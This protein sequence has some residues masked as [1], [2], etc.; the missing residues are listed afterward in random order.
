M[1]LTVF[2]GALSNGAVGVP[3][4]DSLAANGGAPPY[5]WSIVSG[6][7][8]DGFS[9]TSSGTIS[10]TPSRAGTFSFS[11]RATDTTGG[12]NA[13]P[14]SI[15]I[16]PPA[17]TIS[18][19]S[20]PSAIAS[21]PY[22]PQMIAVSGGTQPY[23]FKLD[24]GSL[25]AGLS[26]T[27]GQISGTPTA[28]GTSTFTLT[29]TDANGSS[30]SVP[31]SILVK[32]NQADLILSSSSLSFSLAVG[33]SALPAPASVTVSSSVASQLLTWSVT[34]SPAAL[35]LDVSGGGSTP[36]GIDISLDPQAANLQAAASPYQGAVTITCKAPSPC[37][38][39]SQT[40][41]V[42]LTVNTPPPALSVPTSLVSFSSTSDNPQPASQSLTLQNSGGGAIRVRS[43]TA[44]DGWVSIGGAPGS[45]TGGM[46]AAFPV[47]VNPTGLSAGYYQS[48]ISV[49]TSVGTVTVPVA[50]LIARSQTMNV[51]PA[52]AQFTSA[53]S[54]SFVVSVSGNTSILWTAAAQ[55]GASWL[56]VT[57]P[58][59][60]ST[61]S[62][63]GTVS[64]SIDP[65]AA[66]ALGPGTYYGIIAVS[67]TGAI[68][69]PLNF[70]V[71]LTIPQSGA[72]TALDP[73]PAGLIFLATVVGTAP[74]QAIQVN[75]GA[76]TAYQAAATTS[77]GANWLSV[78][79]STGNSTPAS[80]GQSN[81]S[82]NTG[83]LA[84]G[85]YT[86]GVSY[87]ANGAVRTVNVTL[88]V[89][90]LPPHTTNGNNCT[91]TKLVPTQIGLANN[92]GETAGLP[93]PL[94][95]NLTD[96]CG[97]VIT[98]GQVSVSFSNGD[99]PLSLAAVDTQSG[100]YSGTWTPRN[101]SPQVTVSVLA[102]QAPLNSA[103]S[104]ITGQVTQ[105]SVPLLTPH[106]TLHVFAPTIG[107]AVA[108][109][110]IIQIYGSNLSSG[111]AAASTIPLP[112]SLSG[113][114]VMI[115]GLA[116]PLYYVSPTQINAFAPFELV[117]GA[118]YQV[119]V[120]SSQ[121]VSTPDSVQITNA[122]PG[123]AAL[124]S[125]LAIAQ[126]LD[127]TLVN[128]TSPAR[129][130]EFVIFYLAGLGETDNA[131]ATG[132]ASPSNPLARPLAAV[133]V[134][135]NG[136]NVPVAFAGLT[137]GLVGLYQINLQVPAGTPNGD[138]PLIVSQPGAT[139]NTAILAVHQ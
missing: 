78:N 28:A 110:T 109:G 54:G 72:M 118:N 102:T 16:A 97:N 100:I 19:P 139:S 24:S 132:A 11:A 47:A 135:L 136:V 68:N 121:G 124:A 83:S 86:G 91:P 56:S 29:V 105:S 119:Q 61:G 41:T 74:Q 34:V 128:E 113:T 98:G 26:L 90:P 99:P 111:T 35:W 44:A 115:A 2:A 57:T 94:S 53:G 81:V 12:S 17:L 134:M 117:P 7:L 46:S 73:E 123:V 76:S 130:G 66:A 75:S 85:V 133:T 45:L 67:S 43:I 1:N 106:G 36:G 104:R 60:S 31:L 33:S 38:G 10:G 3:Y 39:N 108:P 59:G 120:K 137:P 122:V 13:G 70:E 129:P 88:I 48:S 15:T 30:A 51:S 131:V 69:S 6:A 138:L 92:F 71:V 58:S 14:I 37:A 62:A 25:P 64:Y 82:I 5:T 93:A 89:R 103:T 21:A 112:T 101:A 127:G 63:A 87:G 20:L 4:S 52:G 84:A 114:S 22:A 50:L 116:A 9:L 23:T 107:G 96:D 18:T 40:I 79:P 65:A 126:H 32:P 80:A 49:V 42:S 95:I 8:P 55:P 77:D 27:A 125:G